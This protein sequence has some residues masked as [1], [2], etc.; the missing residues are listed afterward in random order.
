MVL[1]FFTSCE[2]GLGAQVDVEPPSVVME[3]PTENARTRK[4]V[5]F[6]G[7]WTD[8]LEI[9]Q[10]TVEL[11]KTTELTDVKESFSFI[12][13]TTN[14]GDD[15]TKG[16]WSYCLDTEAANIPDGA[17]T[18]IAT[19]EDTYGHTN[20]VSTVITIDNTPPLIVL[21]SPSTTEIS[22]PM[23]YGKTFSI[24][25]RGADEQNGGT[26]DS[27]DAVIYDENNVEIARKTFTNISTSIDFKIADWDEAS[28]QGNNFYKTIYGTDENA[29]TKNYYVELIAYDDARKVPAEEG[30]RG[31]STNIIYL[32]NTL[33]LIDG[34]KPSVAYNILN[35]SASSDSESALEKALKD[36]AN[37]INKLTFSLN[38]VNNPYFEVQGYE[39]LGTTANLEDERYSFLNKNK[40]TVNVYVGRDNK[41]IR[42]ET[43]GIYLEPCDVNGNVTGSSKVTLLEPGAISSS[44]AIT[45]KAVY[46]EE[47]KYSSA[48]CTW[49]S[50]SLDVE[51]IDGL[52]IGKYYKVNVSAQDYNNVNIRNSNNYALKITTVNSAPIIII[53]E[54]GASLTI[55]KSAAYTVKGVVKTSSKITKIRLYKNEFVEANDPKKEYVVNAS[56]TINDSGVAT[57][58]DKI[59]LNTSQTTV[60]QRYYNFSFEVKG[61]SDPYYTLVVVAFDDN[62]Q[63]AQKEIS[64]ENDVNEPTFDDSPTI[65]PLVSSSINEDTGGGI[66][67]VNGTINIAELIS[68]DKKVGGSWW[69]ASDTMPDA[70]KDEGW[71][72]GNLDGSSATN[73]KFSID[74]TQFTDKS[75]K[76]IHLKAKDASGNIA[77]DSSVITLDVDQ[78]TDAPVVEL[79]NTNAKADV[80]IYKNTWKEKE[81]LEAKRSEVRTVFGTKSNNEM[82][83]T[84]SDDD[85]IASVD[86][87]YQKIELKTTEN[88]ENNLSLK[89]KKPITLDTEPNEKTT[90]SLKAKMPSDQGTY[91]ITINVKDSKQENTGYNSTTIGPFLVAVD[92]GAP[93]LKI[94][95]ASGGFKPSKFSVSGTI[96]DPYAT[97]KRYTDEACSQNEKT[98]TINSNCTW[99]DEI[100]VDTENNIYT[101]YYKAEDDYNQSSIESFS[102][103][104][105][106]K[107]PVFMV[108]SVNGDKIEST[109]SQTQTELLKYGTIDGTYFMITGLVSDFFY[110]TESKPP[111]ENVLYEYDNK[112]N[113]ETDKDNY[114]NTYLKQNENTAS[115]FSE[116][117]FYYYVG[118]T[119]PVKTEADTSYDIT[120]DGWSTCKISPLDPAGYIGKWTVSINFKELGCEN[121]DIRY[122]YFAA[123]DSAGNVSIIDNKI[124]VIKIVID[125][126]SPKITD[127]TITVL[128]KPVIK[129]SATDNIKINTGKLSVYN[130]NALMT[131]SDVKQT[132]EYKYT[133]TSSTDDESKKTTVTFKI[134]LTSVPVGKNKYKVE[135][136]DEAGNKATVDDITIENKAPVISGTTTGIPDNAYKVEQDG[137]QYSYITK[138][139]AS[140]ATVKCTEDNNK[141]KDVTWKD[142]YIKTEKYENGTQTNTIEL[143]SGTC[144][145]DSAGII[146]IAE[147]PQESFEKY[148]NAYVTRTVTATNIYGQTSEWNFY[149]ILDSIEPKLLANL[150]GN[151][152][153]TTL[154]GRNVNSLGKVWFNK[155]TLE[156]KGSYFEEG[157]GIKQIEYELTDGIDNSTVQ[158]GMIYTS[159]P[160][161]KK[162]SFSSIISGF[163]ESSTQKAFNVIKLTATDKAGNVSA[164][165]SYN[166]QI[167]TTVPAL[168]EAA[169]PGPSES[170]TSNIWYRFAGDSNWKQYNNSILT[171][172]AK[173]I[174]LTGYFAD[175]NTDYVQSG[176]KEINVE[177]N[178]KTYQAKVYT[179][180]GGV[181]SVPAEST[182]F[183]KNVENGASIATGYWFATIDTKA[184]GSNGTVNAK[185]TVTDNAGNSDSTNTV[186]FLVDTVAPTVT[187]E[188][189]TAGATLNG[190]NTFSGKVNDSN[191][192]KSIALYYAKGTACPTSLSGFTEMKHSY[193]TEMNLSYDT[194]NGASMSDV[195]AWKFTNYDVNN[196]LDTEEESEVYILPVAYD[197][198]G[199]CSI[200]T[201][202]VKESDCIKITIDLNSDR[203]VI[204]FNNLSGSEDDVYVTSD[205]LNIS[206]DD[207]DGISKL[208]YSFDGGTTWTEATVSS[209]SATIPLGEDGK[210]SVYF[211]IKDSAGATF[212]TADNT[213]YLQPYV[214]YGSFSDKIGN[215]TAITFTKDT[216]T[217]VLSAVNFGFASTS[218]AASTNAKN[219]SAENNNKLALGTTNIAGG[220]L[221]KYVVFEV[222]ATDTASGIGEVTLSVSSNYGPYTLSEDNGHYYTESIDVSSW[223]ETNTLIFTVK[224]KAGLSV[225]NT[226]QFTV[227]NKA[228]VATLISPESTDTQT[229]IVTLSGT[230]N[231]EYSTVEDVRYLVLNDAHYSAYEKIDEDSAKT[232][233]KKAL[234]VNSGSNNTWKFILDGKTKNSDTENGY[235]NAKLPSTAEELY[236]YS[237]VPHEKDI[238]TMTVYIYAKD[239]LGNESFTKKQI[240][241][242][243]YGDR[244]TAEV[245][246]PTSTK[247]SENKVTP[248]N[249]NGAIRVTG[250]A[251]DNVSVKEVYIQLDVN[252]DGDFTD[253]DKNI[254]A[255]CKDGETPIYQIVTSISGSDMSAIGDEF[256]GIKV[257][258]T[259]SWNYTI[260]K[261][262]EL[263]KEGNKVGEGKYAVNI[264]AVAVDNNY[265]FGSWSHTQYVEFDTNIPTIGKRNKNVKEYDSDGTTV[266]ATK[267]YISDMYLKG[268]AALELSVEDKE[269]IKQVMYYVAATEEGLA[270]ATGTKLNDLGTEQIWDSGE[271]KGYIVNIP[272]NANSKYVKVV[273]TKNSDTETT[274]YEKFCVNFDNEPPVINNITL[275]GVK[276][277]DSDKKI[278]NSNGTYFTF[279]GSVT[280]EGNS[281]F[282][283]VLFYYYR[284]GKN[285]NPNRIY[286]PMI[287]STNSSN[288]YAGRVDVISGLPS[289]VLAEQ[290][291]YGTEQT[292]TI[293]SDQ[294]TVTISEDSHIRAGGVVEIN[295]TWL[296]IEKIIGTTVTLKS[297]APVTGSQ[298]VFFAYAQVIDNT[299]SEKTDANGDVSTG[300][301]GDGMAESIIKSLNTWTFDA[302]FHSNYIP[303]GPGKLVV[304]AFDK[305]GNV[306]AGS[307]EASVQNN[308]PRLTRVMLATDLNGD[309]KYQYDNSNGDPV[310]N[311][312]DK[313]TANGTEFGEFAFYSTLNNKGEPSNIATVSLPAG[314]DPFIVKNKLLVVPEFV[315]GN[316]DL[317]YT[318]KIADTLEDAT[319]SKIS[320]T[321]ITLKTFD[322]NV[323]IDNVK[324]NFDESTTTIKDVE[325][326]P[327]T[328]T[329]KKFVLS[330][331]VFEGKE[332][333]TKDA[334][335]KE[336]KE[337]K[338][339]AA[340]F[341]DSTEETTPGVDSCY[342][343]LKMPII[344]NIVDDTD[345]T[346][347]IIPFYWNSKEDS[348]FVYDENGNPLGH[349]DLP[350]DAGEKP[351]V[352]G[353]VYIEGTAWDD[354]RLGGIWMTTPGTN[355]T[356]Q[357]AKYE[358]GKWISEDSSSAT[359]IITKAT[360]NGDSLKWEWPD[361]WVSFE[362]LEDSGISQSGHTVKWRF[363]I[364]MTTYGIKTNQV[365]SVKA[366]DAASKPNVSAENS[367]QTVKDALTPTYIMDFVPYIKSIYT[368]T[369]GSANRSRL[370]KFPVRAG[371]TMTIEG[372]NFASGAEYSVKFYKTGVSGK[373]GTEQ[374]G[375]TITGTIDTVGQIT[376]MAPDYSSWVEV[377]VNNVATKNNTNVN[378]GYN[379]EVGY[380]AK[381]ND[382]G[383]SQANTVGTNFWTDDRYISVWSVAT[384]TLFPGSI[385]PHSG[386]IKKIDKYN[387]GSGAPTYVDGSIAAPAPGGGYLYK[388]DGDKKAVD[389]VTEMNDSFYAAISSDDLKL[390]GYVSGKT[391]TGHGDN[392]GFASS[393]VAYVA[394][395]DEMDYTIIN[396]T[397]YYVIQDNGLGGDSGSVWGL[398]LCLIRE[399]IWYDRTYFN[400]YKGNTI[401]E[402]KLPFFI[403]R[404]GYDTASHKRDSSTG[405]DSIL[406]QFKNPRITG[407]YNENDTLLYSNANGGKSVKGVDYIYVSYYDSYA[408]CLKYAGFR[409]GHRFVSNDSKLVN[410]DLKDWGKIDMSDNIDIVAEMTSSPNRIGTNATLNSNQPDQKAFDHMTD[411]ATVIAG[412]ETT[413]NNPTYTEIAG[414]WSDIFV[415]TTSS[416]DPRPV[417]V[418]Y[419]KTS[420][421][422]EVAY[423]NNSF[424][425]ATTEWT[426]TTGIRPKGVTVDFGRYVSAAMDKKGNLHVAAQDADNAKL[427]YLYLTKSGSS[428]SV[429]NSVAVD[430]SNG[431]GRWTDIE[432]TNPEGTSLKEI[433][434]VI[435]YIDTSYLG[436]TSGIKVAYLEDEVDGRLSFEAITDPAYYT[437]GDQRTSVMSNV[438]E[439]KGSSN[440]SP[441]AVGFNS[442][443]FAVDFLRGEE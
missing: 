78:S 371:E 288:K 97:L 306:S 341:W 32:N 181:W 121:S 159:S 376:V 200:D 7:T 153:I 183:E 324:G 66:Y 353:Q 69:S 267:A 81:Y 33:S 75:K 212:T 187:V 403:E 80:L 123:K 140:S 128:E 216:A 226:K 90:Y 284:E 54:P 356:H 104:Y 438:K 278:V 220:T 145:P 129:I 26:V 417:I 94:E 410:S 236:N 190:L 322:S 254:L 67:T 357:V 100:E 229:G 260:N 272:L 308:A 40:L 4:T 52:E 233:V 42:P 189:P 441:V 215:N 28:E 12:A 407:W 154:G 435:S 249:V 150:E 115:G 176:V 390:Y 299:G 103:K 366:K 273:A 277:N 422:L 148:E 231:D 53:N 224:D 167:D 36:K 16:T 280:D 166:I 323:E 302:T 169:A 423:G 246:F 429:S 242:N 402:E 205:N 256:W 262:S 92:D 64:I 432:L 381:A 327:L 186:N 257:Y 243:P 11:K 307:Y 149:Y 151:V 182:G 283:K 175:A 337:T 375:E 172:K 158:T 244:P 113:N 397:P 290:T 184:L 82:L 188:M 382:K 295:G 24:I 17:Y 211:K 404:Q 326:N 225:T 155:D 198:A 405:Y 312:S 84:I 141:L 107:A 258:G 351:G 238:Y 127:S 133:T 217:P 79:S 14:N 88:G 122:I 433:K 364:N 412:K 91:L 227:D 379:I 247:D 431:A 77:T 270:S 245:T 119:E 297:D 310:N 440:R 118:K 430:A 194:D 436:T 137:N 321:D 27:I 139:I 393:E 61:I 138:A 143:N 95:T 282:D 345:P 180:N 330:N 86:V 315:G 30:D 102:F 9:K 421:S 213:K 279:G 164:S 265:K 358:D 63:Y 204:K 72:A 117:D 426:K 23:S 106:K 208:E 396:G 156:I 374:T 146:T 250:S 293:E 291:L 296:T 251:Q 10:V 439:T 275:N 43:V 45:D 289:R 285:G 340:T 142:T 168:I 111:K 240:S 57:L 85:G 338:Y 298:K 309:G 144:S 62:N 136:V 96:D 173:A 344:V 98:I 199:N 110:T 269:G 130:N 350:A 313:A 394:P 48:S 49:T 65:T 348:S 44:G 380:V 134:T 237:E 101:Y 378:G 197:K 105:D 165:Q 419:N 360:A 124:P 342:A 261:F 202:S 209:G 362:I 363:H 223:S 185:I 400:P 335:G 392:I 442:D 424:P 359:G 214:T 31:N 160:V 13:N 34:Y 76:I 207:D 387:S 83:G 218:E 399:G 334:T 206:V 20:Q 46:T 71:N 108:D 368:T 68:D 235:T 178:G 406:Y 252:K 361:N 239:A 93:K 3:S 116:S 171:N 389:P 428:Y 114:Y 222:Q 41:Q 6:S 318:Y 408:K 87:Y 383:L 386:A 35:R 373:I 413:S 228:P 60:S 112:D 420:K 316:G 126:E 74:T 51:T 294:R 304:F 384:S 162:E 401:E 287:D 163:T 47:F 303:D 398:G 292:V 263:L 377:V 196:L 179:E 70:T 319:M 314:R 192:V 281:G 241:Y 170:T 274:A 177:V 201:L 21:E 317:S 19:A 230:A 320:D 418:Y 29:G 255:D 174:E 253:A 221:R 203:P 266:K 147:I 268:T 1:C 409:A 58:K 193:D 195:S 305:A 391:Y 355:E 22:S 286:D 311:L 89:D 437:A 99:V 56:E 388:Q 109:N 234:C 59:V 346:A 443:M 50:K 333:W 8:D 369:I 329:S 276:H 161:D 15:K 18:V 367:V 427:Y 55:A 425:Q 370:G 336:V 414:E 347:H 343:L 395:V 73:L 354:T 38:P 300:D 248:A 372:M 365:V 385:N 349:I 152:D 25:G 135:V 232:A 301:D 39:S 259:N 352:S 271:T 37:Q 219:T 131:A 328:T 191:D 325:G 415:D 2:I 120:K 125:S 264:R 416:S 339:L 332:S 5:T 132:G 411:G 210:K 331:D 434:P 157:S